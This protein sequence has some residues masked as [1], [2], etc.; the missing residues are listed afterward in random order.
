MS[1]TPAQSAPIEALAIKHGIETS[2][3]DA[4]GIQRQVGPD[5]L[6]AVLA[7]LGVPIES[8]AQAQRLLDGEAGEELGTPPVV[9]CWDGLFARL[10]LAPSEAR[11]GLEIGLA[12]EDGS[13]G[14]DLLALETG[15]GSVFAVARARLPYGVHELVVV[16]SGDPDEI[17][18]ISAPRVP[19]RVGPDAVGI[20]APLYG[21]WEQGGHRADLCCLERLG[22]FAAASGSSYLATLPILAD[23][24][25]SEQPSGTTSPYSPLSRLFWNEGV[26]CVSRV[27]ELEGLAIDDDVLAG[28]AAIDVGRRSASLRPHLP[29]AERALREAGSGR[30][31]RFDAFVAERP[32][33]LS[34]ARFR[35]ACEMAGPDRSRWP[36]SW[37]HGL[38]EEGSVDEAVVSGHV[39]AQFAVDEQLGAVAATLGSG[40]CGLLL[41]LPVGCRADGYDPWAYPE[42][43]ATQASIG[44]PPD[45]FFGEGQD[46]GFPPLHPTG[47]RGAAY[48]MTRAAFS[49]QMRHATALRID[50]AMSLARLWWIPRGSPAKEGAYV[51]YETEELLALA[52]LEAWR[53]EC[54][55]VGE[56]LGTVEASLTDA[57]AEHHI[58]G[59]HVAVFDLEA[60][61]AHPMEPLSPRPG[62]AALVDTHDTATFAAWFTG[63]DLELRLELGLT[64]PSEAEAAR[65]TRQRARRILTDRLVASGLLEEEAAED[66]LS[67]HAGVAVELATSTA[68]LVLLNIEDCWGELDPQNVPGTTDHA[69]FSRPF[70]LDLASI[71]TDEAVI[72]TLSR[73]SEAR[74]MPIAGGQD[75]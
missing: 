49:H 5:T 2:F 23:F 71:E 8:A 42:S 1:A 11:N 62:S 4:F 38:I 36:G 48:A 26:L 28:T 75:G 68:G 3:L 19:P 17:T 7:A 31:Q 53:H 55:L 24:S 41:D 18:V 69:N 58:A 50:H 9:V 46:W 21:L 72:S 34:Y 57:L 73:V 14:S 67:V 59:M 52:S 45:L 10:R 61:E 65:E 54:A 25:R 13:E 37:R 6:V 64:S 66:P 43:F 74:R 32:G 15:E 60:P 30:T 33:V 22:R 29:E 70:R 51:R 56:D 44:A 39:Y 12:L 16:S 40:G 47:E 35:A 63:S 27:P 20:M